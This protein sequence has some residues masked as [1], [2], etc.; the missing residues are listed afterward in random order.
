[1]ERK[2]VVCPK[3]GKTFKAKRTEAEQKDSLGRPLIYVAHPKCLDAPK[4]ELRHPFQFLLVWW[5]FDLLPDV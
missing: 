2:L 1:M 4:G 5:Q 3:C